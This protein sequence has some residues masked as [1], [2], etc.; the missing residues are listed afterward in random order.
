MNSIMEPSRERQQI[1]LLE[2]MLA[3]I[4]GTEAKV[5]ELDTRVIELEH[6]MSREV[7]VTAA[8][9]R[10]LVK[11]VQRRVREVLATPEEYKE[12]SRKMFAA[13]WGDF[14]DEFGVSTYHETPRI[15]ADLAMKFITNWPPV[16]VN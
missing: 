1:M 12:T 4:K 11:A 5:T 14:K 13:L 7:Y 3:T 15:K 9:R 16:G 2:T 10:K 8:Q 6:N